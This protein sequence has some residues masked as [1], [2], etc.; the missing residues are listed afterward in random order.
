MK[1]ATFA[2]R[3]DNFH[4]FIASFLFVRC[5]DHVFVNIITLSHVAHV[6]NDIHFL[7]GTKVSTKA[8]MIDWLKALLPSWNITNLTT[9]WNDGR[10]VYQQAV[11][12]H[13]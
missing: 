12:L 10:Y 9:D 3:Y 6:N 2:S 1:I 7:P 13:C 4:R 11:Y 5:L 8:V